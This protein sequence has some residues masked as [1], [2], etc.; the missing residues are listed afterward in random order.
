MLKSI[1]RERAQSRRDA[2]YLLLFETNFFN[3]ISQFENK[4]YARRHADKGSAASSIPGV[5]EG[6][7]LKGGS[8][9]N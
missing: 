8:N 7:H 1:S 4:P 5:F 6:R 9:G 2:L 3:E